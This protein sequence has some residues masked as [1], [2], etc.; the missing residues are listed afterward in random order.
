MGETKEWTFTVETESYH[1][2]VQNHKK[3]HHVFTVTVSKESAFLATNAAERI[4][5]DY[6]GTVHDEHPDDIELELKSVDA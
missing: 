3:H 4:A 2:D 5:E 1:G 6:H